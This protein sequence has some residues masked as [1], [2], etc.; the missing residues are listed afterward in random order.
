MKPTNP[1]VFR[2]GDVV[3]VQLCFKAVPLK[4]ARAK[5]II[6]FKSLALLNSGLIQVSDKSC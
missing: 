1:C 4:N 3:E 2:V 5:L 6:Q